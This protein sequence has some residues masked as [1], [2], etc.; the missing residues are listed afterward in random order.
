MAG[1]MYNKGEQSQIDGWLGGQSNYGSP[2]IVPTVGAN[3]GLGM[4][5]RVGGVGSNKADVLAQIIEVGTG[6][7]NGYARATISRDQ[8]AGGWP[9]STKPGSSYQST[10]AQKS[11]TFTGAPSPNGATLWFVAGSATTNADNVLFGADTAATRTFG[12]GDTERITPTYQ[13]T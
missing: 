13:A 7:A 5:T 8:T 1:I 9:A 6:T 12:N 11:F 4:G 2:P 3:W 10:T